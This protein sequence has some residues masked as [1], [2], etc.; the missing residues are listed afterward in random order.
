MRRVFIC[1]PLSNGGTLGGKYVEANVHVAMSAATDLEKAGLAVFCDPLVRY[2]LC[3][4]D[5]THC[6]Y[7]E[8]SSC[9]WIRAS[10]AMLRLRGECAEADRL[11]KYA[12]T[13]NKP[14]YHK[15]AEVLEALR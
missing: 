1:G 8:A 7:A 9:E 11:V 5:S 10:D 4:R 3:Q 12:V 6:Q 13:I 14:I 15:V 2:Y